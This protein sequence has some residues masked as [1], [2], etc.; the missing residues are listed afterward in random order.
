MSSNRRKNCSFPRE[1]ASRSVTSEWQNGRTMKNEFFILTLVAMSFAA[2]SSDG[3][4]LPTKERFSRPDA[5]FADDGKKPRD[6]N[7][8]CVAPG[9]PG[10]E[11][12]VGGYCEPGRNDC[13]SE[14]GERFCTADFRDITPID[15]DKWF[16]STLCTTDDECGTGAV[17]ALAPGGSR[18]CAPFQCVT[19]QDAGA[20]SP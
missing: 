12:D 7:A 10:N 2:C 1:L 17:C 16:C 20:Q 4:I 14:A 15:D 8:N 13:E 11:R 18:G 5:A 3:D 6:P 9:T 19:R